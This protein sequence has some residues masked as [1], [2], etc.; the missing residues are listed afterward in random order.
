[1]STWH[2]LQHVRIFILSV[3]GEHMTE[4]D[5]AESFT[6]LLGLNEEEEKEEEGA[7]GGGGD[8]S[9]HNI[10]S[11]CMWKKNSHT[12]HNHKEFTQQLKKH[13]Q[14]WMC[15][16]IQVEIQNIHWSWRSQLRYRWRRLE[17]TSWASRP[18][19]SR[20]AAPQLHSEPFVL[21]K[22]LFSDFF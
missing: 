20:E 1:M 19:Q 17:V 11:D 7:R 8:R 5:V 2:T 12:N 18:Q 10:K 13:P 4:E 21:M 22:S 9:E 16:F 6:I 3:T 15:V 14:F